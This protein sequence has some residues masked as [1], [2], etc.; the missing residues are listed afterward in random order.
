MLP[1]G[2]PESNTYTGV[3]T[4]VPLIGGN[5]SESIFFSVNESETTTCSL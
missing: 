5:Q 3:S 2:T 4:P 1:P